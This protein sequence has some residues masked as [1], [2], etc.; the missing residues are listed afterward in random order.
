MSMAFQIQ[1]DYRFDTNGFFNDSARRATLEAAGQIWSDLI[2]DEF[3]NV[4]ARV[5]FTV[6]NTRTDL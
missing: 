2:Q 1:F 6:T 5:K 3:D 4:A